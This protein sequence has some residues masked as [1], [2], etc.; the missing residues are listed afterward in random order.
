ME[1][2]DKYHHVDICGVRHTDFVDKQTGKKIEGHGWTYKESDEDASDNLDS[3]NSDSGDSGKSSGCYLTTACV[4][5]RGLPDNCLE[6]QV[7]RR[8]RNNILIPSSTGKK[9][10]KEYYK[11]APEIVQ[12]VNEQGIEM[13]GIIWNGVYNDVRKAVSLIFKRDFEGAVRY[14]QEMTLKLKGEYLK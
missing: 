12:A 14:Y 5:A 4:N 10:V 3:S 6:L 9:I 13:S 8:F 1:E 7:L 2:Y 11:I